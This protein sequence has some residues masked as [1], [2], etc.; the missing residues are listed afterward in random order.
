LEILNNQ[1]NWEERDKCNPLLDTVSDRKLDEGRDHKKS[2]GWECVHN[3]Q[4]N[5]EG[6]PTIYRSG[7]RLGSEG[8]RVE[9]STL[10]V[11]NLMGGRGEMGLWYF[12]GKKGVTTISVKEK[13]V[14]TM[15]G[16]MGGV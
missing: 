2:P 15:L 5:Y 11:V 10:K 16:V 12:W 4:K 7:G 14:Q 6:G 3:G 1:R 9:V 8:D 13:Q